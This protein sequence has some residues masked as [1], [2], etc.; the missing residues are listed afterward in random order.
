MSALPLLDRG[1]LA[2]AVNRPGVTL[3]DFWEASCAPCRTLEPRVE[4][5]ARRHADEVIGYRIDVATDQDTPAEFDVH[6][7]PTLVFLRHGREVTRLD[8]LIRDDDLEHALHDHRS[9]D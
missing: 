5:F 2:A 1:Q 4:A 8:G 3:L 9:T 6:S 7:I